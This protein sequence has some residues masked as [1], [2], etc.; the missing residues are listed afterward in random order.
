VPEPF[1]KRNLRVVKKPLSAK[2][3]APGNPAPSK[4]SPKLYLYS[5]GAVLFVILAGYAFAP[6]SAQAT[7]PC[8]CRL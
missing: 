1:G 6:A 2:N 4:A 5:A 3:R 8:G 7:L